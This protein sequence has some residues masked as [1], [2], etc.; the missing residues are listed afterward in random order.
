MFANGI[1]LIDEIKED[2]NQ[3]LGLWRNT[4]ESKGFRIS[5][6]K[7]TFMHCKFS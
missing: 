2:V 1:V 3:K 6:S 7:T 5:R 4:L